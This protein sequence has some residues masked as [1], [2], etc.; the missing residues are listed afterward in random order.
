MRSTE[1]P[2]ASSSRGI[3]P[4]LGGRGATLLAQL[5]NR[6]ALRRGPYGWTAGSVVSSPVLM[7]LGWPKPPALLPVPPLGLGA[8]S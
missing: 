3:V 7:H 6:A 8:M 4:E 2:A 5:A 1:A